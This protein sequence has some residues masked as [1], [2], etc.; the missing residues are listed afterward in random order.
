MSQNH[1]RG[2]QLGE[3]LLILALIAVATIATLQHWDTLWPW[4]QQ[5]VSP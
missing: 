5:T 2:L 4:I 3:Q 1:G